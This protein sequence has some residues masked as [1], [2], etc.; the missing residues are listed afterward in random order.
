MT[1]LNF[2]LRK[3]QRQQPQLSSSTTGFTLVE[4][5]VVIIMAGILAAM[6]GVSFLSQLNRQRL[7]AAQDIALSA[8]R[9]AQTRAQQQKSN[10]KVSFKEEDNQVKW[11][12]HPSNVV[13]PA[14]SASWNNIGQPDI[15][16]D[17]TANYLIPAGNPSQ[18]FIWQ[19]EF[20]HRG[21]V[22]NK[23]VNAPLP[24][25]TLFSS[26][27]SRK[28]CVKIKTILGA[29]TPDSDDKCGQN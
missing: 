28:R 12:V 3:S 6:G 15:K 17:G 18:G 2:L 5:L 1:A 19:A 24:R 29:I 7:N 13:P 9:E 23:V 8:I 14:T 25:I 22:V 20:D 4:L 11:M 26:K 10:W 27:L 21:N 16:I